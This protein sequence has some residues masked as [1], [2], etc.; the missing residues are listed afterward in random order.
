M[1]TPLLRTAGALAGTL[2]LT[3]LSA[4]PAHADTIEDSWP[5]VPE[6]NPRLPIVHTTHGSAKVKP[7]ILN[8][9]PV[10]NPWEDYRTVV[11]EVKEK[12]T[13]VGTIDT[14]NSTDAPLPLTQNL[15]KTET[16]TLKLEGDIGGEFSGV[17]ASIKPGISYSLAWTAG[18]T[19]GPYQVPA[20]ATGKATYGF[21]TVA[22]EGTQQRC[23]L[24][25][26]WSTPWAFRGEAPLANAVQVSIY[27]DPAEIPTPK[28]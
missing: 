16:I 24:D 15:S 5:N 2:A 10:C 14:H 27:R 21:R 26:T 11:Y 22:Y 4:L 7:N 20:R 6:T 23:K 17:K 12:F 18:Q 3:A 19:I 8:P 9:R 13:G 25:G 28:P 1:K